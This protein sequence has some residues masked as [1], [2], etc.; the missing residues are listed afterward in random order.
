MS[1]RERRAIP[2]VEVPCEA[3]EEVSM[4]N[5]EDSDNEFGSDSDDL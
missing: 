5:Q 3:L 4:M 2:H 1:Q